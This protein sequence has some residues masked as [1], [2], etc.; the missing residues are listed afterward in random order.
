MP[1]E[2]CPL[3]VSLGLRA[4]LLWHMVLHLLGTWFSVTPC[5]TSVVS[6]SVAD[7]F[8]SAQGDQEQLPTPYFPELSAE[9]PA[10][11]AFCS[12]SSPA[13]RG[14]LASLCPSSSDGE[15]HVVSR[16]RLPRGPQAAGQWR[17]Q[18]GP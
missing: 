6:L 7:S 3:P 5:V 4:K 13:L 17:Q 8:F 11:Y 10:A 18:Q 2:F 9:T 16:L 14:A 15:N 12:L 1:C